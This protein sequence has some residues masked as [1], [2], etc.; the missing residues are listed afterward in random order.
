MNISTL[1]KALLFIL[2]LLPVNAWAEG[3]NVNIDDNVGAGLTSKIFQMIAL[4]TVLS[5]APSILIMFTSFTRIVVVL[6]ILR[7]AIGLQ[8]SPPNS[9]LVSLA[10]FLTFFIMT[11][12]FEVAYNNGIKP[13]L[14][15]TIDE[16]V[17]F[18]RISEP[19]K[20]FMAEHT[21]GKDLDLFVS[22]AKYDLKEKKDVPLHILTPAF[23][24]SELKRAFEIG[25]LLF[26]PFLIIDMV[27]ASTLMAMGMMM[28]PP[29][30]ISLP[31][32]LIFFVMIDG[33]YMLC[34]SLV[35]SYGIV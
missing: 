27:V 4:I 8:Q 20:G 12:T 2:C 22:I 23:M 6:S 32:K 25:F 14:D 21:R 33:W 13:L 31:F 26:L 7:T 30:M 3:L 17:A 5:L 34:G 11:P 1:L 19:I 15:E 24:L 35:K 10:L 18:A 9:V 29:V 16:T 28:I